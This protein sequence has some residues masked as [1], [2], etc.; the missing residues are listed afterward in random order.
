M[1][2]IYVATRKLHTLVDELVVVPSFYKGHYK[3]ATKAGYV[4]LSEML[5]RYLGIRYDAESIQRLP[6]GKPV[7]SRGMFM[8]SYSHSGDF[9][10]CAVGDQDLGVDIECTREVDTRVLQRLLSQQDVIDRI[11]P[12]RAWVAKEA[13]AKYTGKG[14]AEGF[15]K[16]S[17]TQLELDHP[18]AAYENPDYRSAIF[19]TEED[20]VIESINPL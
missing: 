2:T 4:L 6:G 14:I 19:Y 15:S 3:D 10:M 12:L 8:F 5:E 9:V 7:D 11:D 13:Y 16:L 20:T 17:V 18:N 1:K